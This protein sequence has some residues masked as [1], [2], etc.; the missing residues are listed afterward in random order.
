MENKEVPL[1]CLLN[2]TMSPNTEACLYSKNLVKL[3]SFPTSKMILMA[4]IS[5][6][7][8]QSETKHI[9]YWFIEKTDYHLPI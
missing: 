7:K 9:P 5:K 2:Q 4:L 6:D 8:Y 3:T 1:L